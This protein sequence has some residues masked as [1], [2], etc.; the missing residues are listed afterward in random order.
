MHF[1]HSPTDDQTLAIHALTAFLSDT[2]NNKQVFLLKGYAGTGK[3]SLVAA[4]VKA[5]AQMN[6]KSV[7]LAPTGRAAKVFSAYAGCKA[8]TIHRRIYRQKAFSGEP[9][10]FT[11]APNPHRHALF[12]VDEA[13]MIADRE[14]EGGTAFGSGRLL[15]DLLHF[16]YSAEGC[17]LILMGDDAQLPPVMLAESPALQAEL[18]RS[19]YALTVTEAALTQ[20]VRHE[21]NSD[22]LLNATALRQALHEEKTSVMPKI[23]LS[24]KGNIIKVEGNEI[25]EEIASAYARDGIDSTMVVVRSNSRAR[26]YN[27]GIRSRILYH[28]EEL[29]AGDRLMV[30]RN[31]YVQPAGIEGLDFLANGEIVQV[32]R[33]MHTAEAHGFSF[34]DLLIGLPDYEAEVEIKVIVD[35]LQSEAPALTREEN[36]RLFQAVWNDLEHIS[37]KAEKMKTLKADL[38]YNAVQV[39]YA[40]AITC[41]KAQGGQWKNVFL[42]TGSFAHETTDREFYR[43]LYTALTRAEA[44]LYIVN[45]KLLT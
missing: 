11:L 43:W 16:V 5:L 10:A 30:A 3:T 18:L 6:R 45:P 41:H 19:G 4:L 22:I 14:T 24:P 42:D 37:A 17:R 9:A 21:A 8:W 28:E 13:S 2:Y 38:L 23:R 40:Y 15:A 12:I 29:S 33:V 39:K 26:M 31:N 7:L 44:R 1:P 36:E 20:V 25:I 32:I 27:A 35:A 34:A